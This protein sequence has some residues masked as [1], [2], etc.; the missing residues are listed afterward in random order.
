MTN[1]EIE[2]KSETALKD[3]VVELKRELQKIRFRSNTDNNTQKS[4][5]TKKEIA[6]ILTHLKT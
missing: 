3:R 6:R 1:K 4:K 5:N 2:G